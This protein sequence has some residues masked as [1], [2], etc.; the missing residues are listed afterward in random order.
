[1]YGKQK[2]QNHLI[3]MLDDAQ[4]KKESIEYMR[5]FYKKI[6]CFLKVFRINKILKRIENTQIEIENQLNKV[7]LEIDKIWCLL[8]YSLIDD[9]DKNCKIGNVNKVEL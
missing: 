3:K 9:L 8:S 5:I 1:M 2:Y 7:D 4:S 6:H